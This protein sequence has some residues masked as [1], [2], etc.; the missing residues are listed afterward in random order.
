M[1]PENKMAANYRDKRG[2]SAATPEHHP[3][4]YI[5]LGPPNFSLPTTFKGTL[6]SN[7]TGGGG[8]VSGINR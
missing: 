8:D 2:P 1:Y 6:L 7:G 3:N 5:N 4:I